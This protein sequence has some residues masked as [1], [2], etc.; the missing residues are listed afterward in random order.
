MTSTKRPTPRFIHF[1]FHVVHKSVLWLLLI[2][3]PGFLFAQTTI[4][5][6]VTDQSG[7][8]VT[9]ASVYIQGSSGTTTDKDGQYTLRTS[10][11]G[12]KELVVSSI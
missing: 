6:K 3:A 7:A 1:I 8:S 9:G 5:G 12:D 10:L 2:V 11:T 4:T